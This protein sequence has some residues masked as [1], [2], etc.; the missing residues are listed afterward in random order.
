MCGLSSSKI[1]GVELLWPPED[2]EDF[3]RDAVH[4]SLE[5]YCSHRLQKLQ[6][7]RGCSALVRPFAQIC[8]T[9]ATVHA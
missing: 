4:V 3:L 1:M 9:T 6:S 7:L 2:P 8:A 5:M